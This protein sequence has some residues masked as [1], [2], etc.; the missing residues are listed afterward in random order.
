MN[1]KKVRKRSLNWRCHRYL[2]NRYEYPRVPKVSFT[3]YKKKYDYNEL[4]D[5]DETYTFEYHDE[6]GNSIDEV[7]T[8]NDFYFDNLCRE[9]LHPIFNP[10]PFTIN[11]PIKN[12]TFI[13]QKNNNNIELRLARHHKMLMALH[14]PKNFSTLKSTIIDSLENFTSDNAYLNISIIKKNG[15]FYY[16]SYFYESFLL[17]FLFA[18]FWVRNP[19]SWNPNS[20]V[21]FL[22]HVFVLYEPPKVSKYWGVKYNFTYFFDSY[23]DEG[24]IKTFYWYLLLSQGGSLKKAADLFDWNIPAKLPYYLYKIPLDYD[25]GR[26][27]HVDFMGKTI[28]YADV[29]RLGGSDIDAKRL[30]ETHTFE[31]DF[32]PTSNLLNKSYIKFWRDTVLWFV[33]NGSRITDEQSQVILRWAKHKYTEAEAVLRWAKLN[34]T[35]L[36]LC[37]ISFSWKKLRLNSVL[38]RSYLYDK[39][40]ETSRQKVSN[41]TWNSHNFNWLI[42]EEPNKTWSFEELTSEE[43]LY[44]EGQNLEHCVGGYANKCVEGLSAIVSLRFNDK[45]CITIEL[46]PLKMNILQVKGKYNREPNNKEQRIISQWKQLFSLN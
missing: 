41:R 32:D 6:W 23:E 45:P 20:K 15:W 7:D 26:F 34:N 27:L 35:K 37:E 4:C 16:N 29:L 36:E 46:D 12:K 42:N 9:I 19:Y 30:V 17:I 21:S 43:N 40:F 13:N 38:Q 31:Y 39:K 44:Q 28:M 33:R 11:E 1:K 2:Q 10:I 24:N 25:F 8:L 5:I 22:E 18:P 14:K 3:N